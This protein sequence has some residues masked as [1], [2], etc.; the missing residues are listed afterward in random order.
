M[1]R[2][3]LFD[4]KGWEFIFVDDGSIDETLD[5]IKPY[6]FSNK[7]VISYRKNRGK[8]YAV[9]KGMEKA[10][11]NFIIF[12]DA[13]GSID[14]SQIRDMLNCLKK[15]DVV[16]GTRASK[17]SLV[18][19]SLLRKTIGTFFNWYVDLIFNLDVKDNLC[20]FKGF[21]KSIGK[22][23]FNNL[24]S[25]RWVFD[26]EIFYKIRKEGISLHQM[27]IEWEHRRESKMRPIDPFKM[28]MELLL[29]RWKLA[30][31]YGNK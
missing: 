15:Y 24:M 20:G 31:H 23:L 13:D 30:R 19:S 9:R 11:G 16:A 26:V 28:A 1:D 2:L 17:K 29:L 10:G 21:R 3:A 6:K 22:K 4:K 14:P 7:A 27:P 25:E 8:G 12:I 5:I 18:R